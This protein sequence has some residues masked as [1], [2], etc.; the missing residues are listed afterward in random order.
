MRRDGNWH[1]CQCLFAKLILFSELSTA[2][3]HFHSEYFEISIYLIF[4]AYK[5]SYNNLY[6]RRPN[7]VNKIR[8]VLKR[9]VPQATAILYGSE[10]RGD[11]HPDSDIDLLILLDGT[12]LNVSLQKKIIANLYDIE[13]DTGVEISPK[14]I[15]RSQWHSQPFKTPFYINVTND[16]IIL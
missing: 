1:S 6:M 5:Q 4:F 12:T 8:E 7:V 10:A 3:N 2:L 13:V 16:G 15:L 9:I 14:I 11:A